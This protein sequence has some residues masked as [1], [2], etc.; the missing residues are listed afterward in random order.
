MQNLKVN[1]Y[2]KFCSTYAGLYDGKKIKEPML[3]TA[4]SPN[5]LNKKIITENYTN[6]GVIALLQSIRSKHGISTEFK[7]LIDGTLSG[8]DL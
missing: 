7:K 4:I 1:D 8:D 5:F 2:V 3:E 6:P